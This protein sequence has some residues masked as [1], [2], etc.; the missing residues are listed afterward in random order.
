MEIDLAVVPQR[1]HH[2]AA[3]ALLHQALADVGVVDASVQ[4][5][6]ISDVDMAERLGFRGS[7]TFMINGV[8]VLSGHQPFWRVLSHLP[9]ARRRR[10]PPEAEGR[11]PACAADRA[12]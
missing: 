11:S 2:A 4:T 1:P 5:I 6:T 3:E 9:N 8:D 7:P 10:W 12:G